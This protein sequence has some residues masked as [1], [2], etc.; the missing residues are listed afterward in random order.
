MLHAV[1]PGLGKVPLPKPRFSGGRFSFSFISV[2]FVDRLHFLFP[3]GFG[4]TILNLRGLLLPSY[5]L[6]CGFFVARPILGLLCE[7]CIKYG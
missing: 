3:F 6:G 2:L 4:G 5:A 7:L 1:Q